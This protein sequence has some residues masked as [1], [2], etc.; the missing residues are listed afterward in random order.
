[1]TPRAFV[2]KA[3]DDVATALDD[4]APG[5]IALLGEASRTGICA[6]QTVP[7]GHKIALRT[8]TAGAPVRKYGVIIGTA[9]APIA[10]GGLV[11]C[12]N[13]CSNYDADDDAGQSV[14]AA[15]MEYRVY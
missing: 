3:Q 5:L 10:A 6:A 7:K 4:L 9:T 15:E 14:M 11:H 1:M 13:L 2:I 8:L 12:H